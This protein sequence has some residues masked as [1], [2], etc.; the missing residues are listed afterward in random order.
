MSID[1][2]EAMPG[3]KLGGGYD[4]RKGDPKIS[5]AVR[6]K[7]DKFSPAKGQESAEY[8]FSQVETVEEFQTALGVDSSVSV[9]LGFS[10]GSAKASFE[11]KCGVT[12]ESTFC[13]ISFKALNAP[14]SLRG[15]VKLTDEALKLLELKDYARFRQ[16]FGD[17]FCSDIYT[18]CEFFGSIKIDAETKEEEMEVA[19]SIKA[20]YGPG[21][22]SVS[23][24]FSESSFSSKTSI[25]IF[26]FQTGGVMEPVKTLEELFL[27]AKRVAKQGSS[28]L[29][30]PT[31]IVLT[32][33]DEL[34][35]PLDGSSPF[36]IEHAK[37][38]M[39]R[40]KRLYNQL[41]GDRNNIDYVLA[42]PEK[43]V[44]FDKNHFLKLNEKITKS[45]TQIIRLS[46][47]CA[48]DFSLYKAEEPFMAV[49]ELP[50][51][52]RRVNKVKRLKKDNLI[53]RARSKFRRA[54]ILEHKAK[55]LKPDDRRRVALTKEIKKLRN[56]AR[57]LK[58]K[59]RAR[60]TKKKV[61]KKK[62][63]NRRL[64]K[65]SRKPK[66]KTRANP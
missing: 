40:L 59:A 52:K 44:S 18:G 28:G 16:R 1:I 11:K 47:Q 54:K 29:A 23:T 43:Y 38:E 6:G 30:I 45:L 42:N 41:R 2:V 63:G 49:V 53:L 10:S 51:R 57:K 27:A 35:L 22:G 14:I 36:A 61:S 60:N 5:K 31:E 19:A 17:H 24:D 4:F 34:E 8:N 58:E 13:I 48:S 9:N 62:Q 25:E 55:G 33:Y 64:K 50:Q 21:K 3:V 20:R 37:N 15:D 12:T 56:E 65:A 7:A 26:T 66:R 39:R 46:D 32:P